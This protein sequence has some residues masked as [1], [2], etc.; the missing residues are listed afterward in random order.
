MPCNLVPGYR[1]VRCQDWTTHSRCEYTRC[2]G[3]GTSHSG[4][5]SELCT[6]TSHSGCVGSYLESIP[7]VALNHWQDPCTSFVNAGSTLPR[8]NSGLC[9]GGP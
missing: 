4:C 5:F 8:V 3:P 1:Q 7:T 9:I 2:F 6:W